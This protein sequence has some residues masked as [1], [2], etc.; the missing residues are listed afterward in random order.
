[1]LDLDWVRKEATEIGL[2]QQRLDEFEQL[3]LDF[4]LTGSNE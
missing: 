3:V 4:F 1:M 2:E